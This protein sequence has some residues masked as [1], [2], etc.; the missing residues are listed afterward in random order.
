[1][2]TTRKIT[3][4]YAPSETWTNIGRPDDPHKTLVNEKGSLLYDFANSFPS[5][6]KFWFNRIF[7]FGLHTP[8]APIKITQS[9]ESA[10]HPFVKTVIAYPQATL[11]LLAFAHE[12]NGR[13]ADVVLWTVQTEKEGVETAVWV[14]GQALGKLFVVDETAV[15]RGAD[16]SAASQDIYAVAAH[17]WPHIPS[18]FLTMPKPETAP[19]PTF[20]FLSTPQKLQMSSGRQYGPVPRLRT[21]I[22]TV[23]VGQPVQGAFIFPANNPTNF[24]SSFLRRQ[25]S[26]PQKRWIPAFA[27]MTRSKSDKTIIPKSGNLYDLNWARQALADERAFWTNYPLLPLRWR[28]PDDDMMDMIVSCARNIMQ[29]REIKDG[30]PEFQVGATCYRDLWVVD[31]HFILEAARYL[32][33][34]AASEQGINALLRRVKPNGA[35]Q[36]LSFHE[37]ET[38]I[39]IFSLI[40]HCELDDDWAR[41]ADLWL[42]IQNGVQFIRSQREAS[43]ARGE[44][45]VEYNLMPPAFGDGGLGGTRPE[46]TTTLWTLAGLKK[47]VWAAQKLGFDEDAQH[48]TT[49]FEDLLAVFREKAARDMRHLPDGTPYLP[50]AMPGASSEHIHDENFAGAV[51]PQYRINPGT[52]TW[53]L[54]HAIYPGELFA[55]DDPIV[56]NFCRH[57]DLIDD[58]EG[59]PANTGWLPHNAVWNYAASF[60]AHIW[61]YVGRPDKAI[62]Y[63][64]AFANHASKTRVWREEQSLRSASYEQIVGDMPHNW[65]SAEFVRLT[66]HLLVFERGNQLDLLL[67]L[68]PEWVRPNGR[69]TLEKTPTRYGPV[70]LDLHFGE[71]GGAVLQLEFDTTFSQR[72]ETVILYL[73]EGITQAQFAG[74]ERL[75]CENGRCFIPFAPNQT[76][77][78]K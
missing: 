57:L 15:D 29:A 38:G 71:N 17:A 69:I 8:A 75:G 20:A 74:G 61:L 9:T 6:G 23:T 52:A 62:D 11:E 49:E 70:T 13:R 5:E 40:R 7:S 63:L 19:E 37:K 68:P 48:F 31:G 56:Q 34:A 55:S 45:A 32:G 35:I 24:N 60:Y 44:T 76:I 54:A 47:A 77:Y 78:L 73:P 50:I 36:Q 58:E 14:E 53:A 21:D 59:I 18:Y 67:G 51:S 2:M 27:G 43:R 4:C 28:L 72:P 30:I 22:F 33:H 3:H 16:G 25:E 39:A 42:T 46:Y 66:R 10:R 12:A 64:Y 26:T 41:L 1:M 65:A